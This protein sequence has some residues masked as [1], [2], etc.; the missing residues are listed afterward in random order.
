VP[1]EAVVK[2]ALDLLDESQSILEA[3]EIGL[4]AATLNAPLDRRV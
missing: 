4:L 2:A 1:P 3:R